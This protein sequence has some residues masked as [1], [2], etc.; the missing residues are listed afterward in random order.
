[1]IAAVHG[2]VYGGGNGLVAV[3]DLSYG[4]ADAKFSL[5]ETRI[6][7]AAASITPYMLNKVRPSDLKELIFTAKNFDGNE[8]VKYGLLN[9]SFASL[10]VMEFIFEWNY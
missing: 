5:S 6:G 3:C 1:V 4:V 10:E 7:M 2:N 8:A 9:R